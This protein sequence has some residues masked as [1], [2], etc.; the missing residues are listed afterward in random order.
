MS[1]SPGS[2]ADDLLLRLVAERDVMAT[3]Q[4]YAQCIDYGDVDGWVD[5]FTADGVFE[6]L[7]RRP[8]GFEPW[9]LYEGAAALTGFARSHTH[10]PDAWHK[11]VLWGSIVEVS[12][13]GTGDE[14]TVAST[15]A[16]V[17][18]GESGPYIRA[19]G[20]YTD[21]LVRSDDGRWRISRRRAEIESMAAGALPHRVADGPETTR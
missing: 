14:A 9:G 1:D 16:R 18:H 20:R 6:I 21:H 15:F 12:D 7:L 2:S 17:D 19:F 10:A 3:L 8:E 5:C 4:R 11:H 13:S